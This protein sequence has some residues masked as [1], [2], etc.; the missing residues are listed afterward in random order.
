LARLRTTHRLIDQLFDPPRMPPRTVR[1][2]ERDY[3]VRT[4]RDH[5]VRAVRLQVTLIC[6]LA[7]RRSVE[8]G[9]VA[10]LPSCIEVR[11]AGTRII[12]TFQDDEP[13]ETL[14][15]SDRA[16]VNLIGASETRTTSEGN[17]YRWVDFL[18]LQARHIDLEIPERILGQPNLVRRGPPGN[19]HGVGLPHH[20]DDG[21]GV[22]PDPRSVKG[23]TGGID[24][25]PGENLRGGRVKAEN[26][27][28]TT[29]RVLSWSIG[30]SWLFGRS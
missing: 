15:S 18:T 19:I 10:N 5:V 3:V 13:S 20:R 16:F 22:G 7:T 11:F 30:H 4:G 21:S 17:E 8:L 29:V 27:L 9:P 2:V 6:P 12:E 28:D 24:I 1:N 25:E 14:D 26:N 23:T